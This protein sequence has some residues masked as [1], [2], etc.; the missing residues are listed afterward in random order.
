MTPG[1]VSF[2]THLYLGGEQNNLHRVVQRPRY[3]LAGQCVAHRLDEVLRQG[4]RSPLL[5]NKMKLHAR[6]FGKNPFTS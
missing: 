3:V 6:E 4:H 5:E 2:T 1:S